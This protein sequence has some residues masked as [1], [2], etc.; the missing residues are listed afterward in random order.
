MKN[1]LKD[2]VNKY[3]EMTNQELFY[4][5]NEYGEV[6]FFMDLWSSLDMPSWKNWYADIAHAYYATKYYFDTH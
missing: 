4:F 5:I 6:L 2:F 3:L 1:N